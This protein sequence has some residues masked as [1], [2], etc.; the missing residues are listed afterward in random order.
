MT[1]GDHMGPYGTI[2]DHQAGIEK[3]SNLTANLGW[4]K[5]P[6]SQY[7]NKTAKLRLGQWPSQQFYPNEQL[8]P[9]KK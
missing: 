2:G 9:A 7:W 3:V 8:F 6:G 1:I 5:G 4:A